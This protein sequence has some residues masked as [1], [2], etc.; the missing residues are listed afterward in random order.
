MSKSKYNIPLWHKTL[1]SIEEAVEYTGIGEK[2][3]RRMTLD[4][5]CPFVL[6]IGNRRAIKREVFDEYIRDKYSI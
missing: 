6:W 5:N 4:E 3:L 2:T 1:L